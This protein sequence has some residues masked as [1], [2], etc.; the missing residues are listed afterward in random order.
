EVLGLLGPNG[1]GKTTSIAMAV[2]LLAPSEGAVELEGGQNP[3]DPETRRRIGVAPQELALY[4]ELTGRENLSFFGRVHGLRSPALEQRVDEVL[5]LVSLVDVAARRVTT[6]SGGMK[7]RLNLA[8][9][10]LHEPD[11]VLLDEPTVGV[12]PQSRNA[13]FEKVEELRDGGTTVVYTT[14]YMEEAQRLCDRIAIVDR[15]RLQAVGTTN[16]LIA[17]HGGPGTLVVNEAS[18]DEQ[19]VETLDP[20]AALEDERRK[21]PIRDFRYEPP[22]LETVFLHLTGRALRD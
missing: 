21:R 18:P 5:E 9:A 8:A 14:H 17:E 6:Y 11:L 3:L 13:I 7:R 15:G 1:A 20:L 22:N 4:E 10:I 19:R 16:E 2:G 12:D